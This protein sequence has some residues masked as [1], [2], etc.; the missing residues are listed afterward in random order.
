MAR[1]LDCD[2]VVVGGGSAGSVV[3]GRLAGESDADVVLLEAGPDYGPQ[4][5]PRWPAELLDGGAL[6]T[7]HDWGY[8]SGELPGRDPIGFSRARVIGGCSSHNGCIVAVG[9]AADYDNWAR[10]T[11]DKGWS[12]E[13]LRPLFARALS[14]LRVR[15]YGPAEIGPFHRACLDAAATLG[16][17][18]RDDLDDLDGGVGFGSEPVNVE[19]GVRV[20]AAF[21]YLDPARARLR[22]VDEALCDR[23]VD[24]ADGVEVI[25]RHRGDELRVHA[26]TA[27]LAAGSYG[28]PSIL[29]R[30]G[31]GDPDEL[32]AVGIEPVHQLP[33]VGRNLH[34]HPVVELVF[35][36]SERL[37]DQLVSAIAERFTPEEQTLG[38]LRSSR[39]AGPYDLHV[40]PVA[41]HEHSLLAGRVLIAVGAM[42]AHSRGRLRLAAA[43][44]EAA[45]LLDHGYLTDPDGHDLAVLVEGIAR[46]REL[47]AADP[48]RDLI[49]PEVVPGP[50]AALDDAVPRIHGHYYHPAGTCAM[51]PAS[52]PLAVCDGRGRVYGLERVVVADCSLMPGVPRA[53]TNVPAVVVGERIADTLLA[54]ALR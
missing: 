40:I 46:A 48:L 17:P 6:V 44:P 26:G 28:S 7:T 8:T 29:L 13:A 15:H 41:A 32:R 21:A 14:R 1:A 34:D 50:Q 19:H 37:R 11:G 5:D 24:R 2:V 33:G 16:I 23:I 42:E 18:R 45:P 27:V 10:I 20:N 35:A 22:I 36:G 25:A 49:G 53:N 43:D 38:K 12:A 54:G 52:D 4:G 39:A 30:S 31:V 9:C 47:A 51:G 3:A